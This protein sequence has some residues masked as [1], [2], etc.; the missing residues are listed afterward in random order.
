LRASQPPVADLVARPHR[1]AA[2]AVR[3]G[4]AVLLLDP[5]V[6][7][8]RRDLTEQ[9]SSCRIRGDVIRG[10]QPP[11]RIHGVPLHAASSAHRRRRQRRAGHARTS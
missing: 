11:V 6:A 3:G 7:T 4:V 9:S 8:E 5:P 1:D 10:R 2:R